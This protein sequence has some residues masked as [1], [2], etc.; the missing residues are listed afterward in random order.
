MKLPF[1]VC[2]CVCVC[3]HLSFPLLYICHQQTFKTLYWIFSYFLPFM[4][5][6]CFEQILFS[7]V[8]LL[9][10]T[11]FVDYVF[12]FPFSLVSQ[13][14]QL[15]LHLFWL[16]WYI[17]LAHFF[18]GIFKILFMTVCLLIYYICSMAIFFL[19]RLSHL[20]HFAVPFILTSYSI[21][22][23]ILCCFLLNGFSSLSLVGSHRTATFRRICV[24]L[25]TEWV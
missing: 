25:E 10:Q 12:P 3:S 24:I 5:L 17:L 19:V 14:C 15:M 8:L 20:S 18:K 7:F 13:F 11:C 21:F 9:M 6:L 1:I 23:E 4:A 16:T 2:V 22:V